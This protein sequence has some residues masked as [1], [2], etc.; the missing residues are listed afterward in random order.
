[1]TT[2]TAAKPDSLLTVASIQRALDAR[3]PGDLT[4]T[5]FWLRPESLAAQIVNMATKAGYLVRLSHTQAQWTN[6]GLAKARRELPEDDHTP[7]LRM[8]LAAAREMLDMPRLDSRGE[9]NYSD[10]DVIRELIR[11]AKMA[12]GE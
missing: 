10:A 3:Q 8:A 7:S 12:A 1:M 9:H 2:P 11:H 6:E 4:A 5:D